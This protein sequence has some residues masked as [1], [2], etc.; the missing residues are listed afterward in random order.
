MEIIT[1]ERRTT[2]KERLMAM[3]VGEILNFDIG[4]FN[5]VSPTIS[6]IKQT[7][8]DLNWTVKRVRGENGKV[9]HGTVTRLS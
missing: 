9:S 1:T 3:E 7:N 5:T 4:A 8:P 6:V 2:W